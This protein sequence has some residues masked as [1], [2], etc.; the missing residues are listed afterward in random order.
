MEKTYIVTEKQLRKF[1]QRGWDVRAGYGLMVLEPVTIAN[2]DSVM[3]D[4][5]EELE[6]NE[7][8]I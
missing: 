2:I 4:V 1:V 6:E 3:E 8:C 7:R 5:I